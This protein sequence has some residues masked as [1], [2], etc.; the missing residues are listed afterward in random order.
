MRRIAVDLIK[1]ECRSVFELSQL[2]LERL[3]DMREP[4]LQLKSIDQYREM[5]M[6]RAEGVSSFAVNVGLITSD[7]AEEIYL[8]MRRIYPDV[9][10][11]LE[12]R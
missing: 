9:F 4:Q 8:E 3:N 2:G 1:F 10:G 11:R 5:W 7:E 6:L 12:E